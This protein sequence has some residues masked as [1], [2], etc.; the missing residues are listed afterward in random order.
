M[1]P[2]LSSLW[3]LLLLHTCGRAYR[4]DMLNKPRDGD[5]R[6]FGSKSTSEGRVEI[7]YD[8]NW[9]T[10]CDDNFDMADAAVVCRQLHFP[11]AKS[12]VTGKDYGEAPGPIW[13]DDINCKGSESHLVYCG[14][15]AWGETDCTHKEDVG[16]ICETGSTDDSTHSLDNSIG[17]SDILG[18]IFDSGNGCDFLILLQSP[19]ADKQ[20]DGTPKMAE[21]RICAHKIILSPFPNFSASTDISNITVNI[22]SSCQPYFTSFIRYLYTRK[23]DVTFSSAL[24]LHQMASNFGVTQLMVD[25]GR[26]FSKILPEDTSFFT[27]M[28]LYNYAV[29]SN[30]LI[31][32]ENCVQY[33]AWNYQNLT[34]SPAWT[35]VSAGLLRA[36]LTRS[37][38]VVP[39]EYFVLQ[40]VEE[41]FKK[42]GNYTNLETQANLLSLIRFPLIPAE[43]LFEHKSV[44]S[45]YKSHKNIFCDKMVEAFQF[46][47]LLVSNL[48]VNPMLN[49]E[50]DYQPRIYTAKPWSFAVYPSNISPSN[51]QIRYYGRNFR[52][53]TASP[54]QPSEF[55]TPVHYSLLFKDKRI[56]WQARVLKT[57]RD[58]SNYGLR[59]ESLPVARLSNQ[60]SYN[61]Q[62]NILFH[63]RLLVICQGKFVCQVQDFKSNLA[64]IALNGTQVP[65]YPCPDEQYTYQFVVRPQ[66]TQP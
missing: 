17:L 48:T 42:K 54:Y 8:G 63:N 39:D 20:K 14:F 11:R 50:N 26:L 44:S 6:L 34:G 41:W 53:A 31:L 59:C 32:E 25:I 52:Y 57:K 3:I 64:S 62:E 49:N 33:M 55:I 66:Y 40:S 58:C 29:D 19:T 28:S 15:K 37:D 10:V 16:V 1:L 51:H 30:D 13:L 5:V 56:S 9:G 47:V 43:K 65:A 22:S 2:N 45:L 35:S 12:V 7:Y 23:M 46:N 18:Q 24:C 60:N 27:Q 36:L 61:P 21:T 38:L 4:F